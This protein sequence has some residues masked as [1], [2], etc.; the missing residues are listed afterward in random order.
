MKIY[1]INWIVGQ[2]IRRIRLQAKKS[3]AEIA[4]YLGITFQQV[5]KFETGKDSIKF[6]QLIKLT[7]FCN[8]DPRALVS[9][10][11]NDS[12]LKDAFKKVRFQIHN[13]DNYSSFEELANTNAIED[14]RVY[15][16][17]IGSKQKRLPK[18]P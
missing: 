14:I 7:C 2:K 9:E 18:R 5:H 1:H 16:R 6:H 17:P 10:I 15:M 4:S 8:Y 13:V 3:M 12:Y 11:Y